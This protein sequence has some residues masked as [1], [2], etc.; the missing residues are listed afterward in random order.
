[1]IAACLNMNFKLRSRN[2]KKNFE[3]WV[4]EHPALEQLPAR[5]AARLK[6]QGI[7]TC[8]VD[9]SNQCLA[10]IGEDEAEDEAAEIAEAVFVFGFC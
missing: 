3:Q 6:G 4:F 9:L 1:M 10:V 8:P 2:S 7:N 5:W